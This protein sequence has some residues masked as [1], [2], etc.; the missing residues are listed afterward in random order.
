MAVCIVG[1]RNTDDIVDCLDALAFQTYTNFS[2]VICENG[3][4]MSFAELQQVVLD[5]AGQELRVCVI[6]DH[7]NP[8]YAGGVNHCIAAAPEADYFWI[9]N[10]D[11]KPEREAL[12]ALVA[13]ADVGGFDAVGGV[14]YLPDGTVKTCG[15]VWHP[16][17]AY[18]RS[19]ALGGKL[20]EL[21]PA[22]DVA[23]RL[24]F[25]SGASLLC[26][27]QFVEVTGPMIEDYFLY[28]EEVEWCLRARSKGMRLG[29]TPLALVL[30]KQGT[31]TGTNRGLADRGR[32][33]V[34]CDERNRI[35]TLRD[36]TPI[37][38]VPGAIGALATIFFA[39]GK[40]RAWRQMRVALGAWLDGVRNK[41]GKPDWI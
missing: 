35:L 7:S 3:G 4:H 9:L 15:G 26:S 18:S 27:R 40:R 20:S 37:L 22:S 31:T 2:V 8:G 38:L 30:H 41:R 16:L 6:A 1:F 19:I 23:T 12:A 24:S 21:P 34:Y 14:V 29:Y 5:R 13:A 17:L 32:L 28:G 36:T 10:P 25:I 39:Y 11:T 33:P